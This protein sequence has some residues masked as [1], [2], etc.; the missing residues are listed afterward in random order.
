M[1]FKVRDA[2]PRPQSDDAKISAAWFIPLND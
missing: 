2:N 1:I